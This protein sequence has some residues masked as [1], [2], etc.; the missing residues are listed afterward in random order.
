MNINLVKLARF[1]GARLIHQSVK[2]VDINSKVIYLN[3]KARVNYD[4][5][6]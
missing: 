2:S 1:A 4:V 6:S 5:L 3:N